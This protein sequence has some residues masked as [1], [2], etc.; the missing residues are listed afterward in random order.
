[1]TPVDDARTAENN[2]IIA[3]CTTAL[4]RHFLVMTRNFFPPPPQCSISGDAD[5]DVTS[6]WKYQSNGII[7]KPQASAAISAK[8]AVA[9]TRE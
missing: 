1:L 8:K 4:K 7:S 9:N 3:S 5:D 6:I 2:F